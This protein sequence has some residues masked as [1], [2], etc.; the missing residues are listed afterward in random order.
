M[1]ARRGTYVGS[2]DFDAALL[3]DGS[4]GV[5]ERPGCAIALG[6]WQR[7]RVQQQGCGRSPPAAAARRAGAEEAAAAKGELERAA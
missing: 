5:K 6:R 2:A 3:E 4:W 7:R 1:H